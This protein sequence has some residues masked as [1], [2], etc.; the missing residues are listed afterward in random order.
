MAPDLAMLRG[1]CEDAGDQL[2]A[3]DARILAWLARRD[4]Q[5]CGE[6]CRPRAPVSVRSIH[7]RRRA[8]PLGV[9]WRVLY[10]Q[11]VTEP[12]EITWL[13]ECSPV[14]L[15]EALRVVAPE[16]SGYPLTVPGPA[17]NRTRSGT[18]AASPSVTSSS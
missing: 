15:G 1:A 3:Y 12:P 17:A 14:A 4:P 5:A 6:H 9:R 16:L 11:V 13:A 8:K 10:C 18:R 2:G 7:A